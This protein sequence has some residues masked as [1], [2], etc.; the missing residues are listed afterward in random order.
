VSALISLTTKLVETIDDKFASLLNRWFSPAS[1]SSSDQ[2][3]ALRDY[4][5]MSYKG[6]PNWPPTWTWIDS[7]EDNRPNGEIG[8]LRAV[9]LSKLQPAK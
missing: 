7:R 3:D 2:S 5:L 8:I 1:A 4:P 6:S 9:F